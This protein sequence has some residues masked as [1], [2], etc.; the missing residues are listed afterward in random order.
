MWETCLEKESTGPQTVKK[1]YAPVLMPH[2]LLTLLI[3]IFE[4]SI[5]Y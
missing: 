4:L 5:L 1:E 2:F 3:I